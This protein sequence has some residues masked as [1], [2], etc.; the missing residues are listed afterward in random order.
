MA[1]SSA[2][3]SARTAPTAPRCSAGAVPNALWCAD[4]KG[5]FKL[6]NGRYC[7][8]LTAQPQP[9]DREAGEI[10]EA[11]GTGERQTVVASDGD[12]QAAVAEQP[13][14]ASMT[15]ASRV[16]SRASHRSR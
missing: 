12:R 15:G 10:V 2:P 13:L 1:W 9:P 7:Y 5:E 6:G 3:G 4:V 11:V 16:D 8:P 14:E